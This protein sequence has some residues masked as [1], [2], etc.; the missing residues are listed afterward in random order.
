MKVLKK[1]L[2]G[3]LVKAWQLFLIGLGY[4]TG[5]ADGIFGRKTEQATIDFQ[6]DHDL[7]PDGL[8][9]NKTIGVAMSLGFEVLEDD[10]KGKE[11]PNWPPKPNFSSLSNTE[12]QR[13][14]GKFA[15]EG[16]GGGE[17]RITDDWEDKNI[18]KVE[19]P[20]LVIVRNRIKRPGDKALIPKDGRIKFHTLAAKQLQDLW[21]DWEKEGLLDLVINYAG[22]FYPR[23][24]RGSSSKLSNH[25]FG[26]AFDINAAWNGLGSI[27]ALVG[28]EGSVRELVPLAN[29]YG[30]YWGGHYSR[31]K[32]GMHFEVA[33]V[34]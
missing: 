7:E 34:L 5:D 1:S 28:R 10:T 26:T 16:T 19:I 33:K 4:N 29:K 2:R 9:G 6:K 15:Y 25:A 31:R 24:I 23:F 14:F 27:P 3:N 13:I 8:A 22:A 30:F 18:V 11:G 17:I 32:D 20:Q 21:N 12:R